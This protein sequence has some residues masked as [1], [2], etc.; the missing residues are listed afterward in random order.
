MSNADLVIL[1]DIVTP[2]RVIRDGYVV[3]SGELI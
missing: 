1:G 2:E 3:V